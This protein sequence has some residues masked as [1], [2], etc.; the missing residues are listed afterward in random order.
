MK[1]QIKHI[2][3]ILYLISLILVVPHLFALLDI[4]SRKQAVLVQMDEKK[5]F[6]ENIIKS[7]EEVSRL[8]IAGPIYDEV[9]ESTTD[10]SSNEYWQYKNDIQQLNSKL[11]FL[12]SHTATV[13][14]KYRIFQDKITNSIYAG[15]YSQPLVLC[16]AETLQINGTTRAYKPNQVIQVFKNDKLAIEY[17]R[18]QYSHSYAKIDTIRTNRYIDVSTLYK[19]KASNT[20]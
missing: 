11:M 12:C 13:L 17:T 9:D 16:D 20:K 6:Y 8:R 5:L 2:N 15:S 18:Y 3:L 14:D 4:E 19:H 7:C 1:I 10:T